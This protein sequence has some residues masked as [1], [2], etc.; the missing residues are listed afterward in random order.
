MKLRIGFWD[1]IVGIPAGVLIFMSTM[2]FGALLRRI[3]AYP[4]WIDLPILAADA[5][6]VGALLRLSRPFWAI[7]TS[8]AAGIISGG[9]LLYLSLSAQA[10]DTYSPLI[11][12]IPGIIICL[13]IPPLAARSFP[14]NR[15]P[16]P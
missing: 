6:I 10:G 12:S 15:I 9:I 5:A 11:F 16:K 3:P 4:S 1:I 7:P 14:L 2:M 8:I 13:V